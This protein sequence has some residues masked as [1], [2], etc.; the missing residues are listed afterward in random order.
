MKYQRATVTE[1][2]LLELLA[3]FKKK[4]IAVLGDV[5]IDRY[6]QGIVER[7]SPEAPVPIVFVQSEHLK[8]GLAANVADNVVALG[9][10]VD[11]TGVIGKDKDAQDLQNLFRDKRMG[12]SL[13]VD[14]KRRTILKERI[15]AE[16]Q[17]VLRIDYES[18]E[19]ISENT[20]KR[21]EAEALKTIKSSD[22][23]IIEDY[24]KGLLN[25]RMI[26]ACIRVAK[27]YAIPVLVDP[28]VR[29]PAHWYRGADLLT[30]NKREA[31]ALSGI[32]IIDDKTM[33]GAGHEILRRAEAKSLIIT[34]GREGMAI[35]KDSKSKPTRIPTFAQ[36]VYDVSGAGDT[37]ISVL[38]LSMASGSK[39]E[40]AAFISNI[41]AGVEVSKRGTAT[42]SP[43]EIVQAYLAHER[44]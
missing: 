24:A 18:L 20:Q 11:I 1:D 37:V 39:I 6:T 38:A 44:G 19:P 28:H 26:S 27:K 42:V 9:G 30:P 40:E 29:T 22:A 10:N 17:Q 3:V 36:E 13:I 35:F 33:I 34:L 21:V 2:R 32:R 5:G 16:T 15:V 43:K 14:A 25:E 4:R 31:E 41:A 23:L 8:L 7:I 12:A